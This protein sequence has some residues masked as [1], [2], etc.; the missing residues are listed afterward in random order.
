MLFA[1]V[2]CV[3]FFLPACVPNLHPKRTQKAYNKH[4]AYCFLS[5]CMILVCIL[6]TFK[7]VST[8]HTK[9]MRNEC[10]ILCAFCSSSCMGFW[11]WHGLQTTFCMHMACLQTAFRLHCRHY[12]GQ[13]ALFMC[14][15]ASMHLKCRPMASHNKHAVC[16]CVYCLSA[17]VCMFKHVLCIWESIQNAYKRP[18][19]GMGP[20][21]CASCWRT[22]VAFFCNKLSA[23]PFGKEVLIQKIHT[24]ENEKQETK[25]VAIHT[26]MSYILFIFI[27]FVSIFSAPNCKDTTNK[28]S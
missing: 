17:L 4:A 9:S 13:S 27:F 6:F 11:L 1:F 3:F 10:A 26:D 2:V 20:C 16:F 22:C 12:A 8:I 7:K 14:F 21:L 24:R 19:K 28:P 18:A 25:I 5:V 15:R 23:N